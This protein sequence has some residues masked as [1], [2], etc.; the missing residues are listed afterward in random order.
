[1]KNTVLTTPPKF[2]KQVATSGIANADR[3]KLTGN[4]IRTLGLCS[5][6]LSRPE[7]LS[8]VGLGAEVPLSEPLALLVS[9]GF[10]LSLF[11]ETH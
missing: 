3:G 5:T 8:M 2:S 9:W 7:F 1:M 11:R 6:S 4:L 10:W